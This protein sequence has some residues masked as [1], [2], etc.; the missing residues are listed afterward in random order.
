MGS[1]ES[2]WMRKPKSIPVAEHIL[3]SPIE[4]EWE[5]ERRSDGVGISP[6]GLWMRHP[7]GG[8]IARIM[9]GTMVYFGVRR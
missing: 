6:S 5:E 8:I 7:A 3:T 9:G 1:V 2:N 4:E